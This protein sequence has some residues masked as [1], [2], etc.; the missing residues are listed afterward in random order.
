MGVGPPH[1]VLLLRRRLTTIPLHDDRG[2]RRFTVCVKNVYHSMGMITLTGKFVEISSG[3][4]IRFSAA[5]P[6]GNQRPH[7][8]VVNAHELALI[9][10][11]SPTVVWEPANI[12]K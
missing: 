1:L 10:V 4:S 8:G 7:R 2:R 3:C 5:L 6:V 9:V 12:A 11:C